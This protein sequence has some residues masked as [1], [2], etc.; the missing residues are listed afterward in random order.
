MA[1]FN[2]RLKSLRKERNLTQE[3][4]GQQINVSRYAVLLYE[5][6]TSCPEM[7]GLIGLADYFNVSIDYLV[8][9]TDKPE[10]NR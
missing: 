5:K 3:E 8:G 1:T 6:G 10:V 2:E 4:V 7:K 9:R